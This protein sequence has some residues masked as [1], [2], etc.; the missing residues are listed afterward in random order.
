M[1]AGISHTDASGCPCANSCDSSMTIVCKM[2]FCTHRIETFCSPYVRP[3]EW[4]DWLM[5]YNICRIC[6]NG[7]V[8]LNFGRYAQNAFESGDW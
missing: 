8:S 3:C 2:I 6:H 1:L 5:S 7:R 4:P